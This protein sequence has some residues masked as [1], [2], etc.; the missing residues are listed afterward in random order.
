MG[1]ITIIVVCVAILVSVLIAF[2]LWHFRWHTRAIHNIML[3]QDVWEAYSPY[4]S[5]IERMLIPYEGVKAQIVVR[6]NGT[7]EVVGINFNWPPD[8]V[9]IPISKSTQIITGIVRW[10]NTLERVTLVQTSLGP[11]LFFLDPWRV[12]E[13]LR[14]AKSMI[15]ELDWDRIGPVHFAFNLKGASKAIGKIHGKYGEVL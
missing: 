3:S 8:V 6:Y 1:S 13:R 9:G 10:D 4:T 7:D 5:A 11:Q 12:D 15:L 14:K 2:L